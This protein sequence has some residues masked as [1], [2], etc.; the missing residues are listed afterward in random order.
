MDRPLKSVD[1]IMWDINSPTSLNTITGMMT[2]KGAVNIDIIKKMIHQRLL[3]Y[4]RFREKVA[5]KDNKP[6]W[7]VDENFDLSCHFHHTALP[8]PGDYD[9]L[10]A[11]ISHLMSIPLDPTKPLWKVNLIDNYQGQSVIVYRLHHALAD[12]IALIKVVFSLTGNTPEESLEDKT[13]V[14]E[15]VPPATITSIADRVNEFVHFGESMYHEAQE[16]LK[17]PEVLKQNLKDTWD[18][19]VELGKLFFGKSVGGSAAIYKGEMSVRKKPAWTAQA[20]DLKVIKKIS[21]A[22]GVTINDVLLGLMTGAIRYHMILNHQKPVDEMR[23]VI[24]VNLRKKNET[25]KVENKIGMISL[26]LPIHIEDPLERLK[27]IRT[28]TLILKNSLEPII[29]YNL[30]QVMADVIP[31]NLEKKFA[32]LIGSKVGAVVTN[33][34]GPKKSIYLAGAEVEDMMFW[35]PQTS[36]LGMGVSL[37]SYND[38]AYLGVVTDPNII[39][40]PD[41]IIEGF[42]KEFEVLASLVN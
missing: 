19:A 23:V 40:D 5:I 18:S 42:Y 11:E 27:L 22:N 41:N 29:I 8:A 3:A 17:E 34:P 25:I 7:H 37:I 31:K 14:I 24:P 1:H 13:L 10:Q 32:D 33:V 9:T 15:E 2:L 6:I 21:K 38:K 16:L 26:E 20:I 28:K 35:V 12:G 36:T 4:D 30:L 39:N